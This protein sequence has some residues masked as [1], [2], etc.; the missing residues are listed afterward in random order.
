MEEEP[1]DNTAPSP[2]KSPRRDSF[3]AEG[4]PDKEEVAYYSRK[5]DSESVP[6]RIVDGKNSLLHS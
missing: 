4:D 6:E 5:R 1:A 2:S 3:F